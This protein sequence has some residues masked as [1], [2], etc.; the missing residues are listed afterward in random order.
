MSMR[1]VWWLLWL[2]RGVHIGAVRGTRSGSLLTTKSSFMNSG[3]CVV[4]KGAQPMAVM[5]SISYSSQIE[6]GRARCGPRT[7]HTLGCSLRPMMRRVVARLKRPEHKHRN[8]RILSEALE[9]GR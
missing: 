8:D 2:R 5:R 9:V 6:R 7:H 1:R 3:G 4:H